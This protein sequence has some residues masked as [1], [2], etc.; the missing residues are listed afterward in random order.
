MNGW[1]KYAAAIGAILTALAGT[2]YLGKEHGYAQ[3]STEQ[4][5]AFERAKCKL[6]TVIAVAESCGWERPDDW[7]AME[8]R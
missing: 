3:R 1:T 7:C 2:G 4:D 6:R 8:E 5:E